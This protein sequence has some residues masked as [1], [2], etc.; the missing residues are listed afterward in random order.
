[1]ADALSLA[2]C[3]RARQHGILGRFFGAQRKRESFCLSANQPCGADE[4]AAA[5]TARLDA[6]HTARTAHVRVARRQ[7]AAG[8]CV[9]RCPHVAPPVLG[10]KRSSLVCCRFQQDRSCFFGLFVAEGLILLLLLL[11]LSCVV[12]GFRCWCSMCAPS[13]RAAPHACVAR[14]QQRCISTRMTNPEEVRE[15]TPFVLVQ[16]RWH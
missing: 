9:A 6:A 15:K 16:S 3:S 8:G 10:L 7:S 2:G 1:M 4:Q 12:L 5:H 14:D 11:R 13:H